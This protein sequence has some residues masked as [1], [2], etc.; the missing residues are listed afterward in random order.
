[1]KYEDGEG[2]ILDFHALRHTCGA[3]LVIAG[4]DVKT[5]QTVMRHSNPTLTL[6]TYGHLLDGAEANAVQK[7]A[8]HQICTKLPA[9]EQISDAAACVGEDQ[10]ENPE[11]KKDLGKSKAFASSCE[12]TPVSASATQTGLEPATSGSTVRDSNQLS[13]CANTRHFAVFRM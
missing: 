9:V 2:L 7:L 8:A 13:Y 10:S 6:N 11:T 1:M 12:T 4:V 5:V 3:W